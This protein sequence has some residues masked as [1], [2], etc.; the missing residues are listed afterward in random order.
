MR[1]PALN[2]IRLRITPHG[3]SIALADVA[4]AVH[5][6]AG[7][8]NSNRR[9]DS[10]QAAS[11]RQE[12]PFAG[13]SMNVEAAQGSGT[14]WRGCRRRGCGRDVARH[15]LVSGVANATGSGSMP[16]DALLEFSGIADAEGVA[17]LGPTIVEL[18]KIRVS[19]INGCAFCLRLHTRDALSLG[20]T[21]DRLAVLSAW[22]ETS[23]FSA[24]EQEA[25]RIAE[26]VARVG[27]PGAAYEALANTSPLVPAQERAA[28]WVAIA[29]D[30]LNR[31]AVSSHRVVAP[32]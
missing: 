13:P 22:R 16:Y 23:Y 25:L 17:V 15:G 32:D 30:A 31:L 24:T 5:P 26:E 19:Q 9:Q 20:E 14:A 4:I 1:K 10:R 8:G 3:A 6:E 2:R 29:S 27:H 21:A 18:I 11:R 7:A 12:E 28:R